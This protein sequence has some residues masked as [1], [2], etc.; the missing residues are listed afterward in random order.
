[1]FTLTE[2]L[3]MSKKAKKE[4]VT[5]DLFWRDEEEEKEVEWT[6]FGVSNEFSPRHAEAGNEEKKECFKEALASKSINGLLRQKSTERRKKFGKSMTMYIF[7]RR[8]GM[9]SRH[10]LAWHRNENSSY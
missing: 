2:A 1:M 3:S 7:N 10:Y 8:R 9:F 5:E 4:E 6:D